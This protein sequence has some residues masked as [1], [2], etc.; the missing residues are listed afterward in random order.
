MNVDVHLCANLCLIPGF[1]TL[2]HNDKNSSNILKLNNIESKTSTNKSYKVIQYD[3]NWLSSDLV[4]TYGL[5]RS[6][7]ASEDG[8]VVCFAPP[9]SV[10]ADA[11]IKKYPLNKNNLIAEEFVEGTMINVFWDSTIGLT[12]AWEIATRNTVGATSSFYKSAESKTFRTMFLEAAKENN[13]ILELLNPLYCYSFVL[14]HPLNRI[15][16]PFKSTKLY[17]VSMYI[18]NNTDPQDI[19]VYRINMQDVRNMN[20]FNA[21]INFPEV[22]LWESYADLIEKYASMNTPYT[23]LG[24]VIVHTLTGERTKIRNPVYEEVRS[25]RGNHPKLQYQYISLRKEGK[26][27]DFLKYYPENKKEFSRFRDQIHLFT[28]NLFENYISCYV[29][30]K[31]PLLDF[32]HQYKTHMF[33]LHKTYLN[34]LRND[35]MCVT[36]TVVINYVND[37]HP[38]LLMYCLNYNMRKRNI[39]YIEADANV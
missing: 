5:C 11:F 20:W 24:V 39:D 2:L 29:K 10:S 14:Q 6:V 32:P 21:N 23:I 15:V 13:L 37:L 18:V 33:N 12:G 38:S 26:V 31:T 25:L 22:Y 36:N 34:K 30:K 19:R 16:V 35:K 28:N 1:N 4:S 7:I 17:L 9:K 8:K 3:K 27:G